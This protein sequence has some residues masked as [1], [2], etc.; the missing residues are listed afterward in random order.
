MI[1][2]VTIQNFL[3]NHIVEVAGAIKVVVFIGAILSSVPIMV[4]MERRGSAFLQD[5]LGPNRAS[6]LGFKFFGILHLIADSI[7][8]FLKE[9][10]IPAG[11]N[12]FYYFLA[13]VIVVVA[14]IM[15][16]AVIPISSSIT[17]FGRDIYMQIAH[18]DGGLLYI[19]AVSSLGVVGLFIGGWASNNKYSLMGALRSA[20]QMLSY[21]IPLG[22]ALLGAAMIYGTLEPTE[23]IKYQE[24]LMFGFIPRWGVII[25]PL[26]FILLLVA[27]YAECNRLPFDLP[28]GESEI[29]AGYHTEY[30]SMKFSMFMMAE[31]VAMVNI[32]AIIVTLFFGGYTI[33]W[34]S[35]AYLIAKLGAIPAA[36]IHLA[37]FSVKVGFFIWLFVWVRWTLPRFR[38]DQIMDLGW[39]GLIPLGV[40]NLI[41]T[42][43]ILLIPGIL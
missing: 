17:L 19:F 14:S 7:K 37:V 5:R 43:A 34:V 2:A 41:V 20:A 11:A 42:A 26:G 25:Q 12:V 4:W 15:A 13:P 8:F 29:V 22:L 27:G 38:Y 33:P 16:F 3:M 18:I 28:E 35:S 10:F 1:S 23:M 21:E 36:L 6:I 39:K 32:S 31:Y 30:G 9:S 40:L 24:S